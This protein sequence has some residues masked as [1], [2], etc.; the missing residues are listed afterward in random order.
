MKRVSRNLQSVIKSD[1]NPVF[2]GAVFSGSMYTVSYILNEVDNNVHRNIQCV[3][4]VLLGKVDGNQV[5]CCTPYNMKF[6]EEIDGKLKPLLLW[7]W[8]YDT[9][10][11]RKNYNYV[12]NVIKRLFKKGKINV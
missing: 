3:V 8:E 4:E 7:S 10:E 1:N 6:Y 5:A 9:P 12:N 2:N 11:F